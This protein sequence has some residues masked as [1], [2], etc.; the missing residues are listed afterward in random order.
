MR[1]I[2]IY[3]AFIVAVLAIGLTIGA[4]TRPGPWYAALVKPSFNPPGWVFGPVWTVLYVMIG[5]AGARTW[6]AAHGMRLWFAQMALN[7]AW[8]PAFFGLHRP[9]LALVIV[10]GMLASIVAFIIARWNAD[11]VSALLFIPYA[12]WVAFAS[13]LNAAIVVL[14]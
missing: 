5:I 3:A 9:A 13:L 7:F 6:E 11:R 12:A 10:L 8:S 2:A 4:V 14:N 1:R